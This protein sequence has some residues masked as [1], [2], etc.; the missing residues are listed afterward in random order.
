MTDETKEDIK[1][2]LGILAED[3]KDKLNI[4]IDAQMDIKRDVAELKEDVAVLKK[5]V[6]RLKV[7]VAELKED[8]AVLKK[9]VAELKV[10]VA[11]IKED[12]ISHRD[13]TEIHTQRPKRRKKTLRVMEQ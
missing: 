9:D 4:V 7:D 12:L 10:D 11:E 1:R 8:V 5:D 13:N 3:F 6:A 2:Y